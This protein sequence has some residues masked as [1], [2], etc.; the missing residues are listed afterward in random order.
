MGWSL[1]SQPKALLFNTLI[2]LSLIAGVAYFRENLPIHFALFIWE[3]GW[4]ECGSAAAWFVASGLFILAAWRASGRR[5]LVPLGT[6]AMAL[7]VAME[8]ISW[9]QR[10]L[11]YGS[12]RLLIETNLQQESNLHNLIQINALYR[13]AAIA[14]VLGTVGLWIV[15]RRSHRVRSLCERWAIPI[16]SPETWPYF[17]SAAVFLGL[18][19]DHVAKEFGELLLAI[20][21]CALGLRTLV[22]T[23]GVALR[24]WHAI[25][26]VLVLAASTYALVRLSPEVSTWDMRNRLQVQALRNLRAG[27]FSRAARHFVVVGKHPELVTPETPFLHGLALHA[28][29]E[30][31]GSRHLL[32]GFLNGQID[33]TRDLESQIAAVGNAR[34]ARLMGLTACALA[35]PNLAR[36]LFERAERIDRSHLE[37]VSTATLEALTRGSLAASLFLQGRTQVA[38]LER[39]TALDLAPTPALELR[40]KTAVKRTRMLKRLAGCVSVPV[41]TYTMTP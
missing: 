4:S 1:S 10:I 9:G 7:L 18:R 39:S 37:S 36:G 17:L 30:T 24:F 20:G 22:M 2:V 27:N 16:P 6:A 14:L 29:G 41:G 11:G 38:R 21:F 13:P 12:P 3:D 31:D 34:Q 8:E 40:I 32:E 26:V 35:R 28:A 5:R 15:A 25:T 19:S 33:P 23:K